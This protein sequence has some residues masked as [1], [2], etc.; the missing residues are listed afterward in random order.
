MIGKII[1]NTAMKELLIYYFWYL[2][3][4][5][6][7]SLRGR[8]TRTALKVLRSTEMFMCAPAAARILQRLTCTNIQ[9]Q[10][11]TNR[12]QGD[13]AKL[14]VSNRCIYSNTKILR[15]I[16][17]AELCQKGDSQT[18]KHNEAN[19]HCWRMTAVLRYGV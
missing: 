7:T 14:S 18:H 2:L 1:A 3:G 16:S 17:C 4:M 13:R 19:T 10:T 11:H 6:E 8:S 9:M 12:R 15:F 5:P